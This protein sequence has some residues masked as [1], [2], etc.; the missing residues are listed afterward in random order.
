MKL[1]ERELHQLDTQT[2]VCLSQGILLNV[3]CGSEGPLVKLEK[4]TLMMSL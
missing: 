4:K 1:F 2:L 3:L